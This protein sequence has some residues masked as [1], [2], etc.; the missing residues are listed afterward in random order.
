MTG[1]A[2]S[3]G[4]EVVD[5]ETA[6]CQS[7]IYGPRSGATHE[8]FGL[9]DIWARPWVL[10]RGRGRNHAMGKVRRDESGGRLTVEEETANY[11]ARWVVD[12]QTGFVHA[13]SLRMIPRGVND[14]LTRQ[15][16]PKTFRDGVILP[17]VH[18]RARMYWIH[19]DIIEG[20]DLDYR[21]TPGDF[22]VSAPA[23]TVIVDYRE[24]RSHP[25]QHMNRYPVADVLAYAD[26]D[27]P[28]NRSIEPVLKVGQPAPEIRPASWLDRD[29]ATGPPEVAG[30]VVLVDF[31]G[32]SCGFCVVELP[33]IQAAAAHFA[34]KKD[35]VFIGVHD[36][37]ATADQVAA[38][39]RKRGITFRLAVDRPDA[40]EGWFGA[41]FKDYGVRG[42]PAAAVID[43]KGNVAYVGFPERSRRPRRLLGQ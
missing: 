9:S 39:A 20:V 11:T 40:E 3:N 23:G 8:M 21:P 25:R 43:R 19:L 34:D 5:Y 29:G 32:I 18:V 4:L 27:S 42:I 26:A 16:G 14:Q 2:V 33:E 1:I 6:N 28:R 13:D 31:W 17:T 22:A 36:S 15:Y 38:F 37:G 41:M 7:N 24:D 35:L 10:A 30:K 12:R